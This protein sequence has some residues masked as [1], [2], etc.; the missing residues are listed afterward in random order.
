MKRHLF[1]S[2]TLQIEDV[3]ADTWPVLV[4]SEGQG[5]S[6]VYSGQLLEQ[7]HHAFDDALSFH[8]HP[9]ADL[10]SRDWTG[11][12]GEIVGATWVQENE[13]GKKEVWANYR[14]DPEHREKLARYKNKL[15]LS[16]FIEGDGSVDSEGRFLVESFNES[17]PYKSVDIVLAAGRGGK[18][19]ESLRESYE[20][21]LE[22]SSKP[23]DRS[24]A[25]EHRKETQDM[26]EVTK[27]LEALTAAVTSLVERHDK[28]DESQTQVVEADKVAAERVAKFAESIK[29]IDG[30]DLFESQKT[31]LKE[32][33]ERGEDV[34]AR[35]EEAK[36]IHDEAVASLTKEKEDGGRVLGESVYS[37]PTAWGNH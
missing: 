10:Q 31:A 5:S 37:G 32:A 9:T 13:A 12:A 2:A 34:T 21:Q 3:Q 16:I 7:Y 19:A 28:A 6:G 20:A 30:A 26:D 22:S 29:A 17:D 18:F 33:A 23:G 4:I 35:I 15:G 8:N 27:A 25:Q 11:I 14:P 24:S 1:E 36:A